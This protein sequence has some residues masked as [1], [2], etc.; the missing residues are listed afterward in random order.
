MEVSDRN[1]IVTG[2]NPYPDATCRASHCHH[3]LVSNRIPKFGLRP[4]ITGDRA[5]LSAL[6]MLD[7]PDRS[8]PDPLSSSNPVPT[9]GRA[10]YGFPIFQGRARSQQPSTAVMPSAPDIPE[11]WPAGISARLLQYRHR[12]IVAR[13]SRPQPHAPCQG[14]WRTVNHPVDLVGGLVSGLQADHAALLEGSM[15]PWSLSAAEGAETEDPCFLAVC[16][17]QADRPRTH[18]PPRP[19]PQPCSSPSGR[20]AAFREF[21]LFHRCAP[22]IVGGRPLSDVSSTLRYLMRYPCKPAPRRVA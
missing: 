18:R 3:L 6:S 1:H 21:H 22:V 9:A 16:Q 12:C 4:A 11:R 2:F 19:L 10:A 7:F 20:P 13:N 5:S 17:G 8:K 15:L 14:R